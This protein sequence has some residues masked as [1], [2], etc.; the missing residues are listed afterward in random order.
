[1]YTSHH[2]HPTKKDNK[3]QSI[4]K[5]PGIDRSSRKFALVCKTDYMVEKTYQ[6]ALYLGLFG[7]Y[8]SPCTQG[9]RAPSYNC[10]NILDHQTL[11]Y[12]VYSVQKVFLCT[13]IFVG[14]GQLT[15]FSIWSKKLNFWSK[16][17]KKNKIIII[18]VSGKILF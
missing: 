16:T 7:T 1:M 14:G 6:L 13:K 17:T 18:N 2:S 9:R 15:L 8:W 12:F 3:L 11:S 5:Q 4:I 10:L